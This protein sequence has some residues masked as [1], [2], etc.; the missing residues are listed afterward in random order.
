MEFLFCF[1]TQWIMNEMRVNSFKNIMTNVYF[2]IP[3]L[4]LCVRVPF[5][6]LS[7]KI[8]FSVQ[9][10]WC[11]RWWISFNRFL[12]LINFRWYEDFK[13]SDDRSSITYVWM[14]SEQSEFLNSNYTLS[15][16]WINLV[17][18]FPYEIHF[19]FSSDFCDSIIFI[20][21]IY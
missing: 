1:G 16:A 12:P 9:F 13:K 3:L 11:Q 5:Q 19:R 20:Y 8:I 15:F 17:Q 4:F 2:C 14:Q 18:F 6:L 10:V 7:K 21:L